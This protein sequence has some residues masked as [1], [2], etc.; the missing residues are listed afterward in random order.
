MISTDIFRT[1]LKPI[2]IMA[3]KTFSAYSEDLQGFE[4][5]ANYK[6]AP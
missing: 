2:T 4:V 6:H 5:R 3:A 1:I